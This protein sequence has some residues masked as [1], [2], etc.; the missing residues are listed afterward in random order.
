MSL[1]ALNVNNFQAYTKSLGEFELNSLHPLNYGEKLDLLIDNT[2]QGD[3]II[4]TD[5]NFNIAFNKDADNTSE[6]YCLSGE[7]ITNL[8]AEPDYFCV[9]A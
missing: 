2:S 9:C 5:G 6:D 4:Q 7:S 1:K 8:V 3:V